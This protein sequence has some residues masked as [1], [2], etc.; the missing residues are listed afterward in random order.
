MLATHTEVCQGA[1]VLG[2]VLTRGLLRGGTEEEYVKRKF[3]LATIFTGAA[4]V[5]G[6]VAPAALA[7][8][9]HTNVVRPDIVQNQICGANNG[10]ISHWFHA[11]YPND[12]HPAECFHGTGV[13]NEKGVIHSYCGG[14]AYGEYFGYLTTT[15]FYYH[16][17]FGPGTT[18][19]T[20][21]GGRG[22]L[23]LSELAISGWTGSDKCLG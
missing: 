14:E 16:H 5:T 6:G 19:A 7:A 15:G 10:G 23:S 11:F 22:N 1:P 12:D 17:S 3:K 4:A 20:F 8:S 9:A 13:Q 21:S 2:R 18:R